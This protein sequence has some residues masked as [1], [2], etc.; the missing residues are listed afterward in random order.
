MRLGG[1]ILKKLYQFA[2]AEIKSLIS[3]EDNRCQA[4]SLKEKRCIKQDDHLLWHEDAWQ[5]WWW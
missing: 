4:L 3:L 2:K 5:D 1:R